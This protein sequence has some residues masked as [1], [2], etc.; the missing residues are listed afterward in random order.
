M[1][2]LFSFQTHL[3]GAKRSMSFYTWRNEGILGMAIAPPSIVEQ[4]TDMMKQH[5]ECDNFRNMTEYIGF[6]FEKSNTTRAIIITQPVLVQS[7]ERQ[8]GPSWWNPTNY[9]HK[10]R[11]NTY[12][13]PEEKP[14]TVEKHTSH[15]VGISKLQHLVWNSRQDIWNADCEPSWKL[16]QLTNTHYKVM[17]ST[18]K[19]ISATPNHGIVLDPISKWNRKDKD[20]MWS[21]TDRCNSNM[22]PRWPK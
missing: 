19:Y 16:V 3:K 10:N 2:S 17:L 15:Q 12:Q 13:Q 6:K 9:S 20:F 4:E 8:I 22:L 5:F 1:N 7:L 14:L 11:Y 18:M 21:I